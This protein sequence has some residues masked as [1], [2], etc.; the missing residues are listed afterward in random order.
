MIRGKAIKNSR[1]LI[2]IAMSLSFPM[3]VFAQTPSELAALS[4]QDLM[5]MDVNEEAV[6]D[7]DK[8]KWAVNYSY[9]QLKL[10]GYRKG[11]NNLSNDAVLFRNDGSEA[12][13]NEN[14]PILPTVITQE[15]HTLN[16]SYTWDTNIQLGLT[17]PYIIQSTEHISS[18][19]GFDEFTLKSEGIGDVSVNV[20]YLLPMELS[21]NWAVSAALSFPSGAIDHRGDTPRNGTGTKEQLP[22]TMQLGSGTYDFP[23][24]IQYANNYKQIKYG[25]QI[26]AR[27]RTGKN[28]KG[29]RLGNTYGISSWARWMTPLWIHPG[30]SVAYRHS[31]EIHGIDTSLTVPGPFPFPANITDPANFGGDTVDLGFSIRAC[32]VER[33]CKEYIDFNMRKPVFQRLNG[34]Q[35]KESWHFG[36]SIGMNF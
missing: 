16:L 25:G 20:A 1:H 34:I 10:E 27:I 17:L 26:N 31:E 28:D 18:V 11:K 33:S 4:L 29:Y 9:Q 6:E 30:V 21:G 8:S 19:P 15:V 5:G 14:Y 22:Y 32:S 12:R 7:K 23:L 24:S 13:T 3:Q 35:I 36:A 2:A